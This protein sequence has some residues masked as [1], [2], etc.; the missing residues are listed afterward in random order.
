MTQHT[1]QEQHNINDLGLQ[2]DLAMWTR[3]PIERRQILKMGA[4]GIGVLLA[5]AGT[6]VVTKATTPAASAAAACV[7]EIPQETAGPY[8]ADGSQVSNQYLNALALSGIVRSDIRTSLGTGHTA[9]GIPATIELTLVSTEG[10][11]APLAGYAVYLWHCNR[12]GQYSLYSSGVTSEDY[13]R[14]VQQADSNGKVTFTSIFP[15]CYSGRWPHIHFEIYPSLAAATSASNAIHTTQLALPEDTCRVV[16]AT[17]GYTNSLSNLNNTSLDSDNVFGDGHEWQV[18][19]VTGDT[20][21]GYTVAL[22]VGVAATPSASPSPSPSPSPSLGAATSLTLNGASGGSA[23]AGSSAP[24]YINQTVVLTATP[25]SGQ[26]FLGWQISGSS[27]GHAAYGDIASWDNPLSLT[28]T[29]ATTVTPVFA[30]LPSF[31]D[32]T[33]ATTGATEPIAQLAA[34]GIINGYGDGTFGPNDLTVRAQMAALIVRAM[35]WTGL[36]ATNPF[37]DQLGVDSELWLDVAILAA[38]G[39]ALGYGDG[40]YGTLDNVLNVQ[41]V[42][43]VSRAMVARGYWI[44]QADDGTLYPNVPSSSGHRQDLATYYHYA[45]LV[46]GTASATGSFDGY[47]QPATRAWFAFVLWQALASYFG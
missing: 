29:G 32:V 17:S 18:A 5:G 37:S 40:T 27:V 33:A 4:L 30:A 6:G 16:Y 10:D 47:D 23:Q 35:L 12:D 42:A 45:G 1:D 34:R 44:T 15:A 24:Y 46:R 7:S 41:V 20:T 11:C 36:S 21:N 31:T 3:S 25:N 26:V 43:F 28:L 9:P 38:Q 14:G 19:T 8:P 22:T 2:A 13:L 39:V